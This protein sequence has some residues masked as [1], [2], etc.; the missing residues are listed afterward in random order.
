M[1]RRRQEP[2][3]SPERAGT[4]HVLTPYRGPGTTCWRA[5]WLLLTGTMPAADIEQ[6]VIAALRG[7]GRPIP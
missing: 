6:R 3:T 4:A 7:R 2:C 5:R 1:R